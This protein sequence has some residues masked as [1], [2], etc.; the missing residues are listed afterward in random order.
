MPYN[1]PTLLLLS[2]PS[3]SGK[4]ALAAHIAAHSGCAHVSEDEFWATFKQGKPWDGS[5]SP[6]EEA[7]IQA[8]VIAATSA[9]LDTGTS[10][11]LEFILFH[12]PPSPIFIYRAALSPHAARTEIVLLSPPPEA[13]RA[14]KRL[15]AREGE[16]C[17]AQEIQ[18]TNHQ[19]SCLYNARVNPEWRLDNS[20]LTAEETW[21]RL[22]IAGL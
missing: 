6:E 13:I 5:R 20:N 9:I 7:V 3:G 8:R 2:G 16:R 15:R 11:V 12:N 19:L 10:V 18:I 21:A 17:E 1:K 4:T 14:R 22:S